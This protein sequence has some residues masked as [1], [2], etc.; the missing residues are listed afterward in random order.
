MEPAVQARCIFNLPKKILNFY[1]GT[2]NKLYY[3]GLRKYQSQPFIAL[4]RNTTIL[5]LVANNKVVGINTQLV[6]Y[7]RIINGSVVPRKESVSDLYF[8][9]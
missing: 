5:A 1:T 6:R 3:T 4:P 2:F 7:D 9:A 8:S